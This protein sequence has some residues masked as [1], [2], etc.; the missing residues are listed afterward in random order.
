MSKRLASSGA[1]NARYTGCIAA[2][3]SET[4][5]G[6]RTVSKRKKDAAPVGYGAEGIYATGDRWN[7]RPVTGDSSSAPEG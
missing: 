2:C 3:E 6:L 7:A 5:N 4:R 1:V